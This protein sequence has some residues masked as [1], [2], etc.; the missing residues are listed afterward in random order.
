MSLGRL[1]LLG[2]CCSV[3]YHDKQTDVVAVDM[4]TATAC[5]CTCG[6][7]MTVVMQVW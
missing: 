7:G 2:A 4:Q 1:L 5:E 3:L 6:Y